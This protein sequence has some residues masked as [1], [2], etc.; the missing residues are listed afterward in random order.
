MTNDP[1]KD[2]PIPAHV[3]A[4]LDPF[5]NVH[6]PERMKPSRS[7]YLLTFIPQHDRLTDEQLR[8]IGRVATTW[9]VVERVLAIL[10]SRLAMAPEFPAITV[11]K[12]LS[13]DN[14]VKAIKMLLSLHKERYGRGVVSSKIE[15]IITNIISDFSR[16][17]EK[18]NI[19]THTV[20]FRMNKDAIS[21]L[22]SRS[23][24]ARKAADSAVPRWTVK[25]VDMVADEI[26]K[27]AD[28][29]YVVAQMLP[30]VDEGRHV[31]ALS[32]ED[33]RA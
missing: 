31:E 5:V 23:L 28:A 22:H 32:N 4:L 1:K 27:L 26:Q 14:Q 18:R 13:L 15:K 29:M 24:T 3:R 10:L 19:L 33:R 21:G 25:D 17:K 9:S 2:F 11:V 12:D 7:G 30:E 20:W 8:A 6:N 16:L